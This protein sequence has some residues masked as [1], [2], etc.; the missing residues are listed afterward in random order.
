[1]CIFTDDCPSG[2]GWDEGRCV[3]VPIGFYRDASKDTGPFGLMCP[4]E[5]ITEGTGSTSV[6]DCI[7]G[8]L[9]Y[10]PDFHSPFMT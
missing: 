1:M 10:G 3:P 7:I 9:E 5:F 6:S 2:E 8:K 4:S